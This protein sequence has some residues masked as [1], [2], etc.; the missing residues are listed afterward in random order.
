M[1]APQS[2]ENNV[3][4]RSACISYLRSGYDKALADALWAQSSCPPPSSWA[5][6]LPGCPKLRVTKPQ[7]HLDNPS[8]PTNPTPENCPATT[9]S[10]HSTHRGQ[11]TLASGSGK[12]RPRDSGLLRFRNA[13]SLSTIRR[14][15]AGLSRGRKPGVGV[16]LASPQKQASLSFAGLDWCFGSV[17]RMVFY[18]PCTIL[19]G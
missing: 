14:W 8:P 1:G 17:A 19:R 18:L 12:E 15:Q 3:S 16:C 13:V 4:S 2:W 5:P 7:A 10:T 6:D 11:G 9:H